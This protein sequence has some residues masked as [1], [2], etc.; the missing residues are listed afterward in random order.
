MPISER[1]IHGACYLNDRRAA[2]LVG[3]FPWVLSKF[4]SDP[5]GKRQ[6][7]VLRMIIIYHPLIYG[8]FFVHWS[9]LAIG[10]WDAVILH[11]QQ[12]PVI[13]GEYL[14]P[15]VSLVL[16][17]I[18]LK[19]FRLSEGFQKP[20]LFDS[21]TERNRRTDMER[22]AEAFERQVR[23]TEA[24]VGLLKKKRIEPLMNKKYSSLTACVPNVSDQ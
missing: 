11:Y 10:D 3:H 22:L 7:R 1:W 2:M 20:I 17:R 15:L 9:A 5:A 14:L 24:L 19:I 12:M 8:Y 18:C 4:E 23:L 6:S 16:V 21:E 13:F